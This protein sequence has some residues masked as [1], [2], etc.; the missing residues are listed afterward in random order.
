MLTGKAFSEASENSSIVAAFVFRP[1]RS[2][3]VKSNSW[4]DCCQDF[5]WKN[6]IFFRGGKTRTGQTGRSAR[7]ARGS[8]FVH[9]MKGT[10]KGDS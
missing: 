8:V 5:F 10:E 6:L 9:I 2:G 7:M 3:R 4:R 1:C